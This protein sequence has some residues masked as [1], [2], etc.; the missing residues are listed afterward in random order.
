MPATA[1]SDYVGLDIAKD[2]LDY[3]LSEQQVEHCTN[4]PH[5]HK[6][7]IARVRGLRAP[8]VVC[9]A[10]GGYEHAVVAALLEA[11][12]EVCLVQAGRVRAFA[13]AEG[14]LAKTDRIDARLLR[15]F[16]QKI[17]PRL[18]VPTD[19]AARALRELLEHRRNLTEQLSEVE[20]RL[21]LA[22]Q[23]LTPLLQRQQRFLVAELAA[24]EK[25]IKDHIDQDPGLRQKSERMQQ[26]KGVGPVLAA[27]LL[28]HV[29]EL[30]QIESAK[31]SVLVGVAPFANESGTA[32][33][34]RHIRGGRA[35]VRKVLYMA[36]ICAARFNPVLAAFYQRL[37]QA[38]KPTKVCIVAVMRK[39]LVLLNR[40]IAEPDFV[41]SF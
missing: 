17:H 11:G 27:T 8:R 30:G 2:R 16:G 32:Y 33:L 21:P 28:A 38:G 9:E 39:L 36:A 12:I 13:Y 23:T 41:L 4:D 1:E 40:L 34:P 22:G 10:S 6:A 14:L 35:I 15:R 7:L 37:R 24:V 26:V 19:P 25:L 5:G 20:G 3:A 29:P 18:S 31:I